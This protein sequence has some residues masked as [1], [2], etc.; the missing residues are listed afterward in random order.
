MKVLNLDDDVCRKSLKFRGT[1][2][3]FEY[4]AYLICRKLGRQPRK[5]M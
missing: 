2:T 4:R 1:D 5:R 3:I